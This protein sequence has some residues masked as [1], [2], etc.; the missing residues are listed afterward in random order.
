MK[1]YELTFKDKLY[2]LFE[3]RYHK[4]YDYLYSKVE[5]S[6]LKRYKKNNIKLPLKIEDDIKYY[7]ECILDDYYI[8]EL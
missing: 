3:R 1:V 2:F 8:G 5:K 4:R 6:L 7:T